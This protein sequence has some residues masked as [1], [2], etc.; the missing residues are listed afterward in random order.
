M[1]EKEKYDKND[2]FLFKHRI[3][4]KAG[5]DH[6]GKQQLVGRCLHLLLK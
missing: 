1:I 3:E 2:E 4:L 5:K 6:G